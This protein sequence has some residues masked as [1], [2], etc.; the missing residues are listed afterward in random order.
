M[1]QDDVSYTHLIEPTFGDGSFINAALECMPS[2][3]SI[4]GFELQPSHFRY[5]ISHIIRKP[6][7]NMNLKQEDI[8]AG[9]IHS[10]FSES[11][12][13]LVVGNL[14]WVTVSQLSSLESKNIPKKVNIKGLTG[15]DALTGKSNF[16][17]AEYISLLLMHE[18]NQL[19]KPSTL[20]VLVKNIVAQNIMRYI[21]NSSLSPASLD[22]YEFDAKKEFKVSADAGLM[23]IHFN[24]IKSSFGFEGIANV[25]NLN[26]PSKTTSRF[27]WVNSKFVSNVTNYKHT[28]LID[29][30]SDWNWRSGVKHDAGKVMELS[31]DGNKWTNA[32]GEHVILEP[33][34]LYPL[35]KSSDVRKQKI[36]TKF[37]KFLLITQKRIGEDTS[38]I[39]QQYP[40]TW[41]YLE[42]HINYFND[43]KSS[44][45]KNKD[46]FAIFGIG[47][48]SFSSYKVAIS[49][50]YKVPEFSILPALSGKPVMGDDT[51]YF[52]GFE[53][54]QDAIICA[55]VLNSDMV[56]ELLSSLVFISSKRPYTKDIL[57]RIDIIAAL[58]Q[59]SLNVLQ[60]TAFERISKSDISE[61]IERFSKVDSLF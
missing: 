43:R 37:R 57:K 19:T 46:P 51:V 15:F 41:Q 55:A 23:V 2:I 44:I 53:K 60:K 61:F 33:D 11:E 49:G 54:R 21:P 31:R 58:K 29:H 26:L 16:D 59:L 22:I 45:Y 18:L 56:Q 13:N 48:Y 8:F 17:I 30:E 4:S 7:V 14:P 1:N 6:E 10:L 24:T 40:L 3:T 28:E 47:D 9:Q 52:L 32:L 38:Y 27:G 42:G 34:L 50:M 5:A 39:K 25:H 12:S 20:A 36:H 35:V